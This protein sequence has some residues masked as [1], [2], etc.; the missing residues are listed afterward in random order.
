MTGDR[1][2][3]GW[4]PGRPGD[5][6]TRRCP[7]ASTASAGSTTAEKGHSTV[8]DLVRHQA[9]TMVHASEEGGRA[10]VVRPDASPVRS[11]PPAVAAPSTATSSNRPGRLFIAAVAASIVAAVAIGAAAFSGGSSATGSSSGGTGGTPAGTAARGSLAASASTSAAAS[12][13]AF[14]LSA[15]ETTPSSTSILIDGHGS[16]DQARGVGRVTATIPG[17]SSLVWGASTGPVDVIS[18]GTNVYL[19]VPGISSLTG[20]KQWVEASLS[21]LGS[22]TGSPA[23]SLSLSTL[24]DP[25]RALRMLASLGSP[26]TDVGT[27]MLDGEQTTEYQTTVSVSDILSRLPHGSASTNAATSALQALGVP[28]VPVTVWVGRD[29]LLRQLSI[30]LDLSHASLGSLLGVL[31]S[32][33]SGSSTAGATIDLTVGL[34]H[35]GDPV[36]VSVP[37]ASDV[38]NLN[39]I[40]SSLRGLGSQLGGAL[41]GIASHV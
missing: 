17:L 21:G 36:A 18:D 32:G 35:Y 19:D 28:N 33:T 31:G 2:G 37:P 34:S 39:S 15:T 8:G 11:E 23:G 3:I 27:V 40:A 12:S 29:G 14:T 22:L 16:V 1:P 41:S 7:P 10:L 24:A 30:A 13:V 9:G 4:A 20:G 25:T 5:C 26:V 38:T 6:R